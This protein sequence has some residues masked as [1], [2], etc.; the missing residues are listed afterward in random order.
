MERLGRGLLFDELASRL[1]VVHVGHVIERGHHDP[2]L[3]FHCA[4][5]YELSFGRDDDLAYVESVREAVNQIGA[6]LHC[7]SPCVVILEVKI[8]S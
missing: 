6:V 8:L 7:L 5:Q 4:R 2:G 3:R 1:L